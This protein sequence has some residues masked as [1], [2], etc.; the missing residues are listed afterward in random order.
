MASEFVEMDSSGRI[1][2]PKSIRDKI[3][4]KKKL[5]IYFDE[6]HK[7]IHIKPVKDI[8]EFFGAFKGIKAQ[9]KK[10][11]GVDWVEYPDR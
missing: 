10:D 9:F 2:I 5:E 4:T 8:R 6:T 3:G 7:D 1:V 11:Q